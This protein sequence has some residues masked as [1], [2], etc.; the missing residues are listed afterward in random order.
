MW[1]LKWWKRQQWT[2]FWEMCLYQT[3][4]DFAGNNIERKMW[5]KSKFIQNLVLF[6]TEIDM[7]TDTV[8]DLVIQKRRRKTSYAH[9]MRYTSVGTVQ[10]NILTKP[11]HH[12]QNKSMFTGKSALLNSPPF[13]KYFSCRRVQDLWLVRTSFPPP[14]APAEKIEEEGKKEEGR[15]EVNHSETLKSTMEW[16]CSI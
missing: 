3:F 8:F 4:L 10:R 11:S 6:G 12:I 13:R 1:L 5:D 2:Y 9:T 7:K 16:L 14:L 15:R